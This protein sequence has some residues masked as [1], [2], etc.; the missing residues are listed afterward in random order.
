MRTVRICVVALLGA[1]LVAGAAAAAPANKISIKVP[2]YVVHSKSASYT[3]T[4]S[5]FSRKRAIAYLFLDYTSCA[6]SFAAEKQHP[7]EGKRGDFDFYGVR[8]L[9]AKP[10]GWTSNSIGTDHACAYLIGRASG[11]LLA[12]ARVTF[13]VH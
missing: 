12:R 5:G 11:K 6:T 8:G 2:A 7:G 13:K 10:T 3:V 4:I 1:L 9:F